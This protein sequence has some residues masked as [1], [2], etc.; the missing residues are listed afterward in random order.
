[1]AV[2]LSGSN[3]EKNIAQIFA[4]LLKGDSIG[5]IIRTNHRINKELGNPS[6]ILDL[7]SDFHEDDIF[8]MA[9]KDFPSNITNMLI[10]FLGLSDKPAYLLKYFENNKYYRRQEAM[11]RLEKADIRV[12]HL[13]GVVYL[14]NLIHR[15]DLV[16]FNNHTYPYLSSGEAQATNKKLRM[17]LT[18]YNDLDLYY[19]NSSKFNEETLDKF[20][21]YYKKSWVLP[22][23][24]NY[25][26]PYSKHL[27]EKPRFLFYSRYAKNKQMPELAKFSS[28]NKYNLTMFG[29][30]A[31]QTEFKAEYKKAL[32]YADENVSVLQ[33]V[34]EIDSYFNNANILINPSLH[35]GFSMPIIEAEA[36]SLP[37]LARRGTAMDELVEDGRNGYL[38]DDFEEVPE[39][40]DKILANYAHFSRN[41]WAHSKEYT[42]AKYK[43]RYLRILKEYTKERQKK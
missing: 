32:N 27:T 39:L 25:N 34:P 41:A 21:V 37:I 10:R 12:W 9:T 30:T 7:F 6:I 19:I 35:E 2:F 40:A 16:Q 43:E 18:A 17:E 26:L 5:N 13:A 3:V 22:L 14:F 31:L 20:N 4:V 8:P 33:Q 1:M 28:E 42:Y 36:H 29:N 23:F 38:F 24:H 15:G 11:K